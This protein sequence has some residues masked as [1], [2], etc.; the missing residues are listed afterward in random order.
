MFFREMAQ[1]DLPTF[2]SIRNDCREFLHN[3]SEFSLE[4]CQVWFSKLSGDQKYYLIFHG[5]EVAGY[6]R[7][8]KIDDFTLEIGAD[9]HPDFRG[10]GLATGMYEQFMKWV[11]YE[12][13]T[14]EVL[15]TNVRAYNLYRKLNF[16]VTSITE[17]ERD[18]R[19]I[20]SLHM[21]CYLP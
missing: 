18:G 13:F 10:A 8:R 14:L 6:F 1:Y 3:N 17:I 9:L 5:G 15:A 19:L 7:T 20:P 21:K 12:I 2:L 16:K 4:E 11:P